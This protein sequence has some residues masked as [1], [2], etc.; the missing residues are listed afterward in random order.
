MPR[1][2]ANLTMLFTERAFVDRFGAAAAAGFEGVEFLFPYAEAAD[3]LRER[4]DAAGLALALFNVPPG[5]WAAGER[6][7]AAL[8]GEEARFEQS[9]AQALDYAR[10]LRPGRLHVMAGLATGPAARATYVANL[11]RAAAAAPDLVLTIEPLNARDMPGYHLGCSDEAL[12]VIEAVGAE[13][14]KLQFDLYHTQISE[15]DLTR[16][17]EA[18][19]PVIGHVQIAGVPDRQ[20]PDRGELALGH[21]MDVLDSVGYEGWVGCEY[22]PSGRTEDGLGWFAPWR[23]GGIVGGGDE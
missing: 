3:V 20:E 17:I 18:L 7:F 19:A 14:L 5:D 11:R 21:L 2:A 16:R 4:L 1:F 15:G 22:R 8:P 9:F 12:R 10:V 23:R 13:N 6:G